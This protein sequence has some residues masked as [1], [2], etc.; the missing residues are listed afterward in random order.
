MC[1]KVLKSGIKGHLYLLF[2]KNM[3]KKVYYWK[4][5]SIKIH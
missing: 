4:K 3:V 5:K 2:I 1:E